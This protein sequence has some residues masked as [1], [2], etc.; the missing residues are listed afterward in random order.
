MFD[1]LQRRDLD[2]VLVRR[3]PAEV[4][5]QI[6]GRELRQHVAV[7]ELHGTIVLEMHDHRAVQLGARRDAEVLGQLRDG[8]DFARATRSR[9]GARA[10]ARESHRQCCVSRAGARE[11]ADPRRSCPP[12]RCAPEPPRRAARA[13]RGWRSCATRRTISR[14]RSRRAPGSR[15]P[16][17]RNRYSP[18]CA[19]SPSGTA[20][21]ARRSNCPWRQINL[22][23]QVQSTLRSLRRPLKFGHQTLKAARERRLGPVLPVLDDP[24]SGHHDVA[25]GRAAAREQQVIECSRLG[26]AGHAR[27]CAV[28]HQPIRAMAHGDDSGRLADRERPVFRCIAPQTRA[29]VGLGA[30]GQ[31]A[32]ALACAAAAG[33]PS[34]AAPRPGIRSPDCRN[35][36]RP[37]RPTA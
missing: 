22:Y 37:G 7:L 23:R 21:A 17:C 20:V 6:V 5:R 29:D 13:A 35:R 28:E 26:G 8:A 12:R 36:R 34:S 14:C 31:H 30:V 15:R 24:A 27:V 4:H 9:R 3:G 11:R 1:L 33:T 25:N 2:Q 18:R 19:A 32:A 10:R 16:T